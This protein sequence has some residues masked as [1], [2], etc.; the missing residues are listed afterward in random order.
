MSLSWLDKSVF[1]FYKT[2]ANDIEQLKIRYPEKETRNPENIKLY[3]SNKAQATDYIKNLWG[4]AQSFQ[5]SQSIPGVVIKPSVGMSTSAGYQPHSYIWSGLS[6]HKAKSFSFQYSWVINGDRVELTFCFGDRKIKNGNTSAETKH[7]LEQIFSLQEKQWLAILS[8][9]GSRLIMSHLQSK[10][11]GFSTSWLQ[12]SN[13]GSLVTFEEYVTYIKTHGAKKT[14][15]T[16]YISPEEVSS[17]AVNLEE[18]ITSAFTTFEPTWRRMAN[19][20]PSRERQN[21]ATPSKIAP[22]SWK[23]TTDCTTIEERIQAMG[24]IYPANVIAD[25]HTALH[26]L[27][28][29]HFVILTGISGTGK[30]Q[31]AKAYAHA[32][33]GLELTQEN[34]YFRSIAVQPQWDES[35]DLMGYPQCLKGH[36]C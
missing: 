32:V 19:G 4:F 26:A 30:T 35:A 5:S 24:L 18:E 36:V 3:E 27:K 11:F 15:I 9:P 6:I 7:E 25:L 28:H 29:K 16:K 22:S 10:G 12:G 17:G 34:P 1:D 23:T 13:K 33:Y 8:D 21:D 20:D 31:L 2:I 14:G